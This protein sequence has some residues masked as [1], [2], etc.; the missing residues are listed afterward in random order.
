MEY[1]L[2]KEASKEMGVSVATIRN[3]LENGTLTKYL[4]FKKS[5]RIDQDEVRNLMSV[6]VS[7]NE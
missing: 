5:V 6:R 7:K 3:Y 2:V 4:K 1:F